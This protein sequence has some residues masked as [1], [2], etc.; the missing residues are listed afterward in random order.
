MTHANSVKVEINIIVCICI[1]MYDDAVELIFVF[2]ISFLP[3]YRITYC[4]YI[5]KR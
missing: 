1:C 4:D 2:D 3:N 5:V